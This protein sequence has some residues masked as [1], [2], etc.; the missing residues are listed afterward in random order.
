MK[1]LITTILLI[2]TFS[3]LF[4]ANYSEMSTQELIAIMGY[5]DKKDQRDFNK[6]IKSRVPTMT[7]QEKAK[8]KENLSKKKK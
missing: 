3:P 4:A 7:A 6:E 5:V 8:Y 2:F 1:K